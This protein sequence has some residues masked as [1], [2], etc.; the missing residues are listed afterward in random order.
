VKRQRLDTLLVERGQVT[1]RERA[2][3]LVMA[4]AVRVGDCVVDKPSA[5]VDL[6]AQI[7]VDDAESRF[8]S[9]GGLK[10]EAALDAFQPQVKGAFVLDVGASTGGFTDCVLQRGARAV[11][12]VD[13]GYGQFA[14]SLR[15]DPRVILRER[16][17]VRSLSPQDL[18]EAP[19][20]AVV[21][22]SFISLRLVLPVVVACMRPGGEI[23]TL[24]KPQFEV[25]KGQ[26]GKGGVVRDARLQQEVVERIRSAGLA[27]G[28]RCAAS[29]ESPILG[30]KG[31]REFFLDFHKPSAGAEPLSSLS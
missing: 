20:L 29:C 4:G 22:V 23:I 2:R 12:A 16:T 24:V 3:R 1:S 9:R 19:S 26:V 11:Y 21:D 18:P 14:W 6:E 15:N 31:N 17:N 10:L 8:V 7:D 27:L 5:L 28:L 13:V 25:G 30:P